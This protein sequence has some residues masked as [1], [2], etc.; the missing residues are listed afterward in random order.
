VWLDIRRRPPSDDDL[1]DE[2]DIALGGISW[3]TVAQF[4]TV[5]LFFV[6][7][8]AVLD[9]ARNLLLPVVSAFVVGSMLGPLSALASRYRIPSWLSASLLLIGF[10]G[11]VSL[12]LTLL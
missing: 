9:L 7:F 2:D 10:V 11:L 5:G 4:A 12:I 6:V 3:A 8:C 1:P